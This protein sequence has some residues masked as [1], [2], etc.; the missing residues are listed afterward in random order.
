[1]DSK[2]TEL[3]CKNYALMYAE[4]FENFSFSESR[5]NKISVC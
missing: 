3:Y 1:M 4:V 5:N 2:T